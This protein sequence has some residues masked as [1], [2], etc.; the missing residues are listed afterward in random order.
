MFKEL[1]ASLLTFNYKINELEPCISGRSCKQFL[2]VFL[3]A[4]FYGPGRSVPMFQVKCKDH[5]AIQALQKGNIPDLVVV[6]YDVKELMLGWPQ[7]SLVSNIGT[8]YRHGLQ[9]RIAQV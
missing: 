9:W 1:I 8:Y 3:S 6:N 7:V 5:S 2:N 4:T